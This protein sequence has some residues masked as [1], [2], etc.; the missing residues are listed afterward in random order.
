MINPR[1]NAGIFS[2]WHNRRKFGAWA[3]RLKTPVDRID[4]ADMELSSVAHSLS[5]SVVGD[6][7]AVREGLLSVIAQSKQLVAAALN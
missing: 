7:D 2:G 4:A 6:R 3:A 1:D 5:C